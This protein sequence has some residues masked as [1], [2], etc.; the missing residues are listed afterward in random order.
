MPIVRPWAYTT[1]Y[2]PHVSLVSAEK[3]KSAE[4]ASISAATPAELNPVL[5]DVDA[6]AWHAAR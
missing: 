2:R 4:T 1:V 5:V 6:D 3:S